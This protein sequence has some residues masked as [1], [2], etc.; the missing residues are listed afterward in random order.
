MY[1]VENVCTPSCEAEIAYCETAIEFGVLNHQALIAI[2]TYEQCLYV[3]DG[4]TE[5]TEGVFQKMKKAIL[6]ILDKIDS[7]IRGFLDGIKLGSKN[8]LTVDKYMSSET[9]QLNIQKDIIEIHKAIDA[10]F[11]EMR[12]VVKVIS[13][14]SGFDPNDVAKKCDEI[15]ERIRANKDKIKDGAKGL[16]KAAAIYKI[17]EDANKKIEES[18]GWEK[19]TK[20]LLN[21]MDTN[22]KHKT[23][24]YRAFN[25]VAE[26]IGSFVNM[27]SYISKGTKA[28]I[29][30]GENRRAKTEKKNK[31]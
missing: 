14:V 2:D 16:V 10:E 26:T 30:E 13:N 3:E 19:K 24:R 8:R 22:D 7:V 6:D 28:A 29:R 18:W 11:M 12:K 4:N 17:S 21:R 15:T 5:A 25:K 20:E 23:E 9:A 27:Y 31:K 1:F